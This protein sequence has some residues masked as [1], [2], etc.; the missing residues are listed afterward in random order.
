M[1]TIFSK[2][3]SR[4]K[5]IVRV[6]TCLLSIAVLGS[7][8]TGLQWQPCHHWWPQ[9]IA[10]KYHTSG[11][12]R[13]HGR[14]SQESQNRT[15]QEINSCILG[16]NAHEISPFS[17]RACQSEPS[18]DL[19]PLWFS[20]PILPGI[21]SVRNSIYHLCLPTLEDGLQFGKFYLLIDVCEVGPPFLVFYSSVKR[22]TFRVVLLFIWSC[23]DK[24]FG[25]LY[26]FF[27]WYRS[28]S[29]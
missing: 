19:G 16:T 3:S 2:S 14:C 17:C 10:V 9:T 24:L 23:V 22:Q 4:S 15:Q 18:S 21:S 13:R 5:S 26:S 11:P 29:P 1:V 27:L 7:R 12:R 25:Y 20:W 6:F 8:D 28:V